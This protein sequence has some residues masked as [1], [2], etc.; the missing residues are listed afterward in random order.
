M[1]VEQISTRHDLATKFL[2]RLQE[3]LPLRIKSSRLMSMPANT[4]CACARYSQLS[5]L[6]LECLNHLGLQVS[7]T[8]GKSHSRKHK[9]RTAPGGIAIGEKSESAEADAMA[10]G[11]GATAGGA[12]SIAQ[13]ANAL[14]TSAA[15]IAIG[16][17]AQST[18]L[19]AVAIGAG[20][21]STYANSVAIGA[22]SV[23][24]VGAL[25][26]YIGYGLSSPSSSVGEVNVGNRQITGVAA[27]VAATDAVNV[28]QLQAV[29]GE[30]QTL[31]SNQTSNQTS[32]SGTFPSNSSSTTTA[33]AATGSNS[34]AGGTGA[35]AS[36]ANSTAVGT[37]S[38]ASGV[39]STVV[40]SGAT[41]TGNNSVAIGAGSTDDGRT[42]VVSVGSADTPRQVTNV[43]AGTAPTDAV[44]VQQ[45]NSAVSQANSY[46]DGQIQQLR[47]DADA[48]TAAAMAVAGLPQPSGPGKSMVAIAGSY[49]HGQSGQAIGVSTISENNHW[50][51]KAAVTTNTRSYY[52]AVVGAGYQW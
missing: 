20:A 25:S 34:S 36:G 46:T 31:I 11:S 26:N 51:Y 16:S 37:S 41:S 52:G 4:E 7:H 19:N 1:F 42:N 24:T 10:L 38:T 32:N 5:N 18:A 2:K 28:S 47:H 44:N 40:G 14:A 17:G 43:A 30:L 27:G 29:N 23:T 9:P 8:T 22:G 45:L 13:G 39:S 3:F 15:G 35:V 50:I 49:Y 21:Q 12:Q 6:P 48:G 33:A